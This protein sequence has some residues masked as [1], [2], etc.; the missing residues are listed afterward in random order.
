MKVDELK[1]M[2]ESFKYDVDS[3][4][5]VDKDRSFNIPRFVNLLDQLW[6]N[7][8]KGN[9]PNEFAEFVIKTDEDKHGESKA[10]S[11]LLDHPMVKDYDMLP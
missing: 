4:K 11:K 6:N 10:Y 2:M 8:L 9:L 7:Y 5:L 1:E 3:G